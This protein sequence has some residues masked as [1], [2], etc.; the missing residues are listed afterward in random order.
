MLKNKDEYLIIDSDMFLI[1]DFYVEKYREYD[2]A[3]VLQNRKIPFVNYI[4]N[5]LFYFNTQKM[6]ELEI[7]SWDQAFSSDVG[8]MTYIWLNNKCKNLPNVIDI[9]NSEKNIF[10]RN[11][12]Y[13]IK[14]LWSLTWNDNEMP[15]KIKNTDL[16][17]FIKQDPRNQ[18]GKYF[19]EIYDDI[20]LHYR[21]GGDWQR[22]GLNFHNDLTQNLK[23][24]IL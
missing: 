16:E 8:G 10:N 7:I 6:D 21:A 3:I 4:W 11:G 19:C 20:F 12:I 2:C 1:N 13:F 24:S 15:E 5:G 14:H 9:R 22:K 18:N 23:K 17:K